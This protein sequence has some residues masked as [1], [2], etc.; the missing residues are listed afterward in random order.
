MRS[1]SAFSRT[2]ARKNYSAG[3]QTFLA[4][5]ARAPQFSQLTVGAE[6]TLASVSQSCS[7][8]SSQICPA[9]SSATKHF[10]SL[11]IVHPFD[12]ASNGNQKYSANPLTIDS[13]RAVRSGG[14]PSDNEDISA[15]ERSISGATGL[16]SRYKAR[17]VSSTIFSNGHR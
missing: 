8:S 14:N 17:P 12:G 5:F 16:R 2:G 10:F 6:V 1:K 3:M 13:K 11:F 15:A 9:C 7:L 4:E